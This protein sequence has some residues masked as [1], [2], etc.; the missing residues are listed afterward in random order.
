MELPPHLLERL[1]FIFA[2]ADSLLEALGDVSADEAQEIRR[3]WDAGLPPVTSRECLAVMMGF[4]AGFIHSMGRSARA[5]YR[6][7]EIPKGAGSRQIRAPKVGIKIIQKWLCWHFSNK[8]KPTTSVYGFVPGRSHIQAARVHVG[9]DW[10]CSVDIE[11]FFP[12]VG[13]ERIS[14]ALNLLGYSSDASVETLISV[15]AFSGSLIQGAPT[16]PVLSNIVFSNLDEQLERFAREN[17]FRLSRYA[18][19]IVVS[20]KGAYRDGTLER[21]RA[22]VEGD[23]WSVNERKLEKAERP[24]RLKV[25]GLLVHGDKVRLTKGYRNR[26]R[27]YEHLLK[28]GRL[29][30]TDR[31]RV[32]GHINFSHQVKKS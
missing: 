6:T 28:A 27:A 32:L 21:L 4:N 13:A 12:S 24:E 9:A 29:R 7:F 23:G 16:S 14:S 18:D 8:F 11:E 17:D 25:H 3:L 26:I 10:I 22:L 20:G 5:H 1:G 31:H 15:C 19:D 30:P 2:T